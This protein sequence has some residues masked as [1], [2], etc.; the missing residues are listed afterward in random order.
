MPLVSYAYYYNYTGLA[1]SD[2]PHQY[3][4]SQSKSQTLS[5]ANAPS[6]HER[7]EA[8]VFAG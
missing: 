3:G 1:T 8:A 2:L 4:I 6:G 5:R 7:R